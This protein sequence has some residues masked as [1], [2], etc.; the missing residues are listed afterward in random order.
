MRAVIIGTDFMK[1]TDGFFK[2]LETNTN[3]QIE[4]DINSFFNMNELVNFIKTNSFN[5]VHIIK[6][7]QNFN[8][9]TFFNVDKNL[10]SYEVQPSFVPITITG[11]TTNSVS[12]FS[13]I[14]KKSFNDSDYICTIQEHELDINSITIPYIE[15]ADNKLIIR[16]A[17]DTTALID[18]EYA[19]DNWSYLKL[20]NDID[21]NSIPKTYINDSTLG[22]DSIGTTIR[23]NGIHPNYII[24]KR[25]TPS[26]NTIYPLMHKIDS[27]EELDNLKTSL[28]IDEYIQEYIYNENDLL[29]NRLQ[30]YRSIDMV[31]GSNL[32]SLNLCIFQKSNLLELSDSTDYDDNKLVQKWERPKYVPKVFNRINDSST[33]IDADSNSKILLSDDTIKLAGEL[34]VGDIVKSVKISDIQ[35]LTESEFSKFSSSFETILQDSTFT[36]ASVTDINSYEYYGQ[37]INIEL[38]NGA[39]FSDVPHAKIFIEKDNLMKLEEYSF[40]ENGNKVLL[41][42]RETNKLEEAIITNIY[43]TLESL[44]SYRIT[45]DSPHIFEILD[46]STLSKYGLITHNY[47]YDCRYYHCYYSSYYLDSGYDCGSGTLI[48]AGAYYIQDG[49]FRNTFPY[50]TPGCYSFV[51]DATVVPQ[52]IS[53]CNGSKSDKRLKKNI[54]FL[55]EQPNG[56]KIYQ[57]EFRNSIILK[58]PELEGKWQGVIAQDLIDTKFENALTLED[59]GFFMV[60]YDKLGF[61]QIQIK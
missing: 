17:Y 56:L 24:K 37:I 46:E 34:V 30:Y 59:D 27:I 58:Q 5:E 9:N 60:N 55:Y 33:R 50:A 28:E 18:D 3:I 19:K 4:F 53:Y 13:N 26:D 15:D 61:K 48:T 10:P 54:E 47:T 7:Y 39:K 14:L 42:N 31:Y 21:S 49:C 12:L 41:I 57:Y 32:D 20:M 52:F 16:F 23:D 40:I 25:Y 29:E 43:Y 38:N 35:G 6:K 1:D 22:F 11:S 8:Q 44:I 45:L 51:D 2:A 36:T